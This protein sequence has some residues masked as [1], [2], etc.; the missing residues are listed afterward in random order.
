MRSRLSIGLVASAIALAP[1]PTT[2]Q[3][4]SA[5]DLGDAG[6]TTAGLAI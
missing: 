3:N 5:E 1:L 4:G 2:A 6:A